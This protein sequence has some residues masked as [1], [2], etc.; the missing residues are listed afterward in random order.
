MFIVLEVEN[1]CSAVKVVAGLASKSLIM[2]TV[3][4]SEHRP[5]FRNV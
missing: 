2:S 5:Q 1:D 3:H 4:T